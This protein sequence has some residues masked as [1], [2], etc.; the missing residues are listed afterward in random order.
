MVIPR[1]FLRLSIANFQCHREDKSLGLYE[2]LSAV[3]VS[4]DLHRIFVTRPVAPNV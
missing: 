4:V 2:C 1:T 3:S